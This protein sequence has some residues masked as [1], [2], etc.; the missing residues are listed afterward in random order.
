MRSVPLLDN[1]VSALSFF[2]SFVKMFQ[3]TYVYINRN[4]FLEELLP[5]HYPGMIQFLAYIIYGF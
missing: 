5:L 4:Y 1:C 3:M 2:R